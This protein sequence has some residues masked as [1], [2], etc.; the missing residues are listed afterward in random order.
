M[1]EEQEQWEP[2]LGFAGED[3]EAELENLPAATSDLSQGGF[4]DIDLTIVGFEIVPGGEERE[5]DDG[6]TYKTR[7]TLVVHNRVDDPDVADDVSYIRDFLS[8]PKKG[9]SGKRGRPSLGSKYGIWLS[10]WE[11]LGVSSDPQLAK[12]FQ[13]ASPLELM[14]IRYH[15]VRMTADGY[16]GPVNGNGASA[17]YGFDNEYRKSVGLAAAYLKSEARPAARVAPRTAP[18][19]KPGNAVARPRAA[20]REAEEPDPEGD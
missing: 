5:R 20:V 19:P 8:L 12:E 14:G 2:V 7:D 9:K 4:D 17:V 15:R 6:T 11:E 10:A 13:M 16:N 3:V 1:P 18:A